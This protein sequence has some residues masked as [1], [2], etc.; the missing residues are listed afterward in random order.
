[1]RL[2]D[3]LEIGITEADTTTIT[4]G[5]IEITSILKTKEIHKK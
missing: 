5:C 4:M 1:M 2:S 3:L